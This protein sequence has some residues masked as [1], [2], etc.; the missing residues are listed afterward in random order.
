MYLRY[1]GACH[2]PSGQGDG[3][4]G[5][6]MRPKPLDLTRLAKERGGKF[7]FERVMTYIDGSTDVRAHGDASMP[8]WGA[9]FRA[10]PGWDVAR[11]AEARGKLMLI[12]DYVRS[13]QSQ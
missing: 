6:L 7:P 9:E 12:T 11:R 8:V 10:Q 13:I 1:C 2:G 4:A 5:S 3:I